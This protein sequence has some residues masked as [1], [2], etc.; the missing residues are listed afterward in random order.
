[1][2]KRSKPKRALTRKDFL[3]AAGIGASG[4]S[5]LGAAGCASLTKNL[6]RPPEEY[7]PSGGPG[8]NVILIIL[9]SL[10]KDH[11]GAYGND[12]MQT[13]SLDAVA[14]EGLR[15]TR[16][17]PDAMPTLPARRA[18]HTGMRTF[19]LGPPAYGWNSIPEEQ[20]TL[21][22]TLKKEGYSTFLVTDTY[23]QFTRNFGRGFEAYQRIRGQERDFYKDPSSV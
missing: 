2:A 16:A 12:R 11:V 22:E 5:L 15:F 23:H 3:R 1:M 8:M 7:L 13:P 10:R 21:A 14:G 4:A 17:H 9:D 20:P 18:I 19:P 6:R